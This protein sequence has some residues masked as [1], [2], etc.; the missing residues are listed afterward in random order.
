MLRLGGIAARALL[1]SPALAAAWLVVS[2]AD[3][4][5]VGDNA[6]DSS[7]A[8]YAALAAVG[9][10]G[11]GE[12]IVPAPG[13]Y[14]TLPLNLTSNTRLT[15]NGEVWAIETTNASRWPVVDVV[16]TYASSFP[17][18][19]WQPFIFAPGPNRS[20]N[21]SIAGAGEINGAGPFWWCKPDG[22]G[23]CPNYDERRP[24]LAS[25]HNVSGLEISGVTLRNSAFWTLR[26]VFCE[27]VHFHDM[28]ITTPW[29]GGDVPGGPGGPN[30]DGIDVD[31]S[32][33]VMIERCNISVGDDHITVIAGAGASGL[34]WALPSRNVTARD[35][36]LGTGM[37]LS[38][39]SSVSGGVSDVLYTR[40]VMRERKQDWGLGVSSGVLP[41]ALPHAQYQLGANSDATYPRL[42]PAG[43]HQDARFVRWLHTQRRVHR[44]RPPLCYERRHSDRD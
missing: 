1:L 32:I 43:A 38:V 44:Q 42:T 20:T 34:L 16:K 29:C 2:V 35:N 30:T 7:A 37:G 26:P 23:D 21:I 28:T 40:N 6:T 18:T 31:S 4:G 19:R 39:G 15:V 24:H 12:V 3:Y 41:R 36:V 5:A 9:A 27:N 33:N 25:F 10:A 14:K 11:G 22:T 17:A 13:L 8:F